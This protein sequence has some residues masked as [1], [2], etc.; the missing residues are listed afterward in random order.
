MSPYRLACFGLLVCSSGCYAA[1]KDGPELL[2]CPETPYVEE[3]SLW[4]HDTPARGRIWACEAC[5]ES[6]TELLA[7]AVELGC[8][9]PQA[10]AACTLSGACD[11]A[12]HTEWLAEARAA[13]G[14]DEIEAL[15]GLDPCVRPDP[16]AYW[17]PEGD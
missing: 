15:A 16:R 17:R 1:H 13:A 7:R 11:Y 12:A 4:R 6:E 10:H 8:V 9:L 2:A 5:E 3:R 14:C